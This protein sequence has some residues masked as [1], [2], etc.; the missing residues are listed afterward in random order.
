[1]TS[2]KKTER[3]RNMDGALSEVVARPTGEYGLVR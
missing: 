1:M 2:S 3:E